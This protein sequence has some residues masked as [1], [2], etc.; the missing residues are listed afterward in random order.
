MNAHAKLPTV[1]TKTVFLHATGGHHGEVQYHVFP[2]NMTDYGYKLIGT[3]EISF[4]LEADLDPVALEIEALEGKARK[5][6]RDAQVK[7]SEIDE[8][9]QRLRCIT[10]TSDD[11]DDRLTDDGM[12]PAVVRKP[13]IADITTID[14]IPF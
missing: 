11:P 5:L 10:H 7:I 12:F 6:M 1:I 14:D 8:R 2:S 9:I 13:V 4:V 3:K